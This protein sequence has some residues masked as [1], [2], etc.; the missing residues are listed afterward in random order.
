MSISAVSASTTYLTSIKQA[1]SL[2]QNARGVDGDYKTPGPGRSHVKDADGDYKP[3]AS[4]HSAASS[5]V[6]AALSG[7]KLGG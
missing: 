1:T 3:T 5:A 6:Q 7:L 2:A 4:A